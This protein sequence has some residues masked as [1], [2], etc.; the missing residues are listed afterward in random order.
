VPALR[1]PLP[2]TEI[3]ARR[4]AWGRAAWGA[5]LLTSSVVR[6]RPSA[7]TRIAGVLGARH[8]VQAAVTLRSPESAPARWAWLADVAHCATAL[9]AAR[10][11]RRWRVPALTNAATAA[12]WAGLSA[13]SSRR[14]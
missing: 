4:V 13:W 7:A 14:T 1:K 12:A 11:S 3:S 5:A 2:C 10:V 9:A 6:S 8:L